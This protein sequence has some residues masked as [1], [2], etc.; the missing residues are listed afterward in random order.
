MKDYFQLRKNLKKDFSSMPKMKVA[1]LGDTATQFLGEMI[2]AVAYERVLNIEIW[3]SGYNQI[4][5]QIAVSNSELYAYKP[6]IIVLF[7][8]THKLLHR[9]NTLSPSQ[10]HTLAESEHDRIIKLVENIKANI[11]AKIILYN[12]YEI[13]DAVFGSY[14]L[15]TES[16]FIFQW[17]KLNFELMKTAS[18]RNDLFLC[19]IDNLQRRAGNRVFFQPAVYLN[20]DMVFSIDVLPEVAAKTVDIIAAI[21]GAIKKCVILDLDNTIWG[22]I[23]GEDGIENIQIGTLGIGKAFTEFQYWLKKLKNRG[24]VL[25][26]CSKNDEQIARAPFE[27]HPDMIL[28]ME[29]IAVFVANWNNKAENIKH[30][31]NILNIG[32]D[33]MVFIDDSIFERGMIR[34]LLPEVTVPELPEDPADYIG[35]LSELNLF[36]TC[37]FSEEDMQRTLQYKIEA[38]RKINQQSFA[39][40]EEYLKNLD[41][42]SV[43]ETFSKYNIPR[44]AQLTQRS[45]QFNLRTVRYTDAD[46]E[47]IAFSDAYL[48]FAFNLKDKF[49][50][51][52]L[53]SVVILKKDKEDSLFIDTWLMSCRVLKR[54]ME[55]FILNTLVMFAQE[56][57][58]AYLK[59]EYIPTLKN[60]MVKDLYKNLGF[61]KKENYWILDVEK[62]KKLEC[63]IN[64]K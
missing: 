45:N 50:D 29:D 16:A 36:E 27:K 18:L 30:I 19:D 49:G 22:G 60:D 33:A 58:Y 28:K 21:N 40:E 15:K 51:N 24:I 64:R 39:S 13:N 8:A 37:S 44:V 23:I 55:Q 7:F 9:Y 57:T 5:T 35:Y 59:G 62:Y 26:V 61:E 34:E 17:H 41:M 12:F 10:Y 48:S 2:R 6:D 31:K 3:E 43:V 38:Q 56:N 20:S 4:E 1:V 14:G 54:G 63:F 53:I 46:I 52:G 25:A 42:V 47:K 32:F 11:S